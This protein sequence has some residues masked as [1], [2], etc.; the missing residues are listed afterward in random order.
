MKRKEEKNSKNLVENI[1]LF[2][3]LASALAAALPLSANAK[4]FTIQNESVNMLVV[5][6]TTGNILLNPNAGFG[7]VGIGTTGPTEKLVVGT[8]L[9]NTVTGTG[10]VIGHATAG[11]NAGLTIGESNSAEATLF[12]S[13][14]NNRLQVQTNG[15]DYPILLGPAAAGTGG[16]F[17]DTDTNAGNVGI[18]TTSPNAK[19]EVN[20]SSGTVGIVTNGSVGIGAALPIG[21]LHLSGT[22]NI[23]FGTTASH[24]AIWQDTAVSDDL[25]ISNERQAGSSDII[26]RVGGSDRVIFLNRGQVGINTSTPA[27]T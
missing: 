4:V 5:N 16:I 15:N 25:Y 10:L 9:G 13:V 12:W 3:V 11:E 6:G 22:T 18:G 23:T 2:A 14:D 27:N 20:V 17:I 8:D 24:S 19:L 7:N 26:F 1:L 21:G